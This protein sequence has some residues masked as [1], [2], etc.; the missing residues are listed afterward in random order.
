NETAGGV[1]RGSVELLHPL[2]DLRVRHRKIDD[3]FN[4]HPCA[5]ER[6][7]TFPIRVEDRM[8][9]D[10]GETGKEFRDAEDEEQRA[11]VEYLG[12][13]RHERLLSH[14]DDAAR[15]QKVQTE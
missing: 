4:G 1:P 12:E 7:E 10:D 13:N 6:D 5:D 9:D 11:A 15:D 14:H 2:A 8:R 3:T